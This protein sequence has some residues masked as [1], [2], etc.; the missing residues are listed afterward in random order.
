MSS[1]IALCR[2]GT[3]DLV[4]EEGVVRYL[5]S[6]PDGPSCGCVIV[7]TVDRSSCWPVECLEKLGDVSEP[8]TVAAESSGRKFQ[9]GDRVRITTLTPC[10]CYSGRD[11]VKVGMEGVVSSDH[12]CTEGGERCDSVRIDFSGGSSNWCVRSECL[13]VISRKEKRKP[14]VGDIVDVRDVLWEGEPRT[15]LKIIEE[16]YTN[17]WDWFVK[18]T[19]GKSPNHIREKDI[20]RYHN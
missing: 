11:Y 3:D 10:E 15:H 18:D 4:G 14:K 19:T 7:D 6:C 20:I 5:D 16:S 1:K 2:G 13:E 9:K 8:K 17:G 12:I